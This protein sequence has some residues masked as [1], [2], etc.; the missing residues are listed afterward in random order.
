MPLLKKDLDKL[1]LLVKLQ[2]VPFEYWTD[3]EISIVASGVGRPMYTDR[4]TMESTRI[5]FA[6]ICVELDA[7]IDFVREV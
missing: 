2:G 5:D 1:P 6:R 7:A 4:R 3:E